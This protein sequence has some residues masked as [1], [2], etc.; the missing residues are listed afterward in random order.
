[1]QNQKPS[2]RELFNRLKDALEAF[3]ASPWRVHILNNDPSIHIED[4][5]RELNLRDL[6][7]YWDLVYDCIQLAMQDPRGCYAHRSRLK[8]T[9]STHSGQSLWP[10]KVQHPDRDKKIYFKFCIQE[11]PK[12]KNYIHIDCHEDRI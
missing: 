9:Y 7:A 11:D 5:L 6:D 2:S 1:M 4:D 10:F 3:E 8:S 12:G